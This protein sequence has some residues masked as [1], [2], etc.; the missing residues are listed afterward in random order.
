MTFHP[1]LAE[2]VVKRFSLRPVAGDVG[3]ELEVEGRNLPD[4]IPGW[5]VHEER[6]LRGEAREYVTRGAVA[7]PKLQKSLTTAHTLLTREGTEV[8]LTGRAST[9]IHLNMQNETFRVVLGTI[10]VG[11]VLEPWLLQ[12]CGPIRNGNLFCIPASETHDLAPMF[13][14][15]ARGIQLYGVSEFGRHSWR[16]R[17]K[18]AAIN[19]DPL[20]QF[21]TIE[22]R[23]FPNCIDPG[24]IVKWAEWVTNI[25]EFAREYP[26]ETF[27]SLFEDVYDSPEI[28]FGMFD[29]QVEKYENVVTTPAELIRAGIETAYEVWKPLQPLFDYTEP[30]KKKKTPTLTSAFAAPDPLDPLEIQWVTDDDLGRIAEAV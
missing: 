15:L 19:T 3:I 1:L 6:S 8:R 7:L 21:G 5:E 14:D 16:A 17:G 4:A 26:D 11:V 29:G 9:H 2:T 25:R 20:A 24:T 12:L 22:F 27:R 18:Y 23:C 30:K 28:L 10:L 13:Q